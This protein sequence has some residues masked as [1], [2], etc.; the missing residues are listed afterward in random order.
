MK[1]FS[2]LTEQLTEAAKTV[3]NRDGGTTTGTSNVSSDYIKNI[4]GWFSNKHSAAGWTLCSLDD[5]DRNWVK[6]Q[7][8]DPKNIFRSF[9]IGHGSSIRTNLICM[10]ATTGTYGFADSRHLD[11]TD[12]LKFDKKTKFKRLVI[13]D[14][15]K[16]KAAFK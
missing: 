6:E 16:A 5:F 15:S 4:V 8:H 7:G 13:D 3:T 1:T 11:M 9:S 12:E 14:N 2:T 10:N